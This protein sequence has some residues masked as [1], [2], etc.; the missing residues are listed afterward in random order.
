MIPNISNYDSNIYDALTTANTM[1]G[2]SDNPS[3][4]WLF[5]NDKWT[6]LA[7][8]DSGRC[9]LFES[10]IVNDEITLFGISEERN[11]GGYNGY[12]CLI[13]NNVSKP[14]LFSNITNFNDNRLASLYQDLMERICALTSDLSVNVTNNLTNITTSTTATISTT[15]TIRTHSNTTI[16][17][18]TNKFNQTIPFAINSSTMITSNVSHA[19]HAIYSSISS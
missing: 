14:Q 16:P 8:S 19:T 11:D 18:T 4:A 17:N 2:R 7:A 10:M 13:D 12:S 6:G 9:N 3:V 5:S 15:T 1:F